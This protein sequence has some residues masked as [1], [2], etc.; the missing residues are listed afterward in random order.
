[1]QIFILLDPSREEIAEIAD[2]L[3]KVLRIKINPQLIIL[4][5]SDNSKL[6]VA[7]AKHFNLSELKN[8]CQDLDI[9]YDNLPDTTISGKARELVEHCIRHGSL[10]KLINTLKELRPHVNWQS[11]H[12]KV[13]IGDSS[14]SSNTSNVHATIRFFSE[15]TQEP[16]LLAQ[17]QVLSTDKQNVFDFDLQS[18]IEG[19][20]FI[21]KL[22]EVAEAQLPANPAEVASEVRDVLTGSL[23]AKLLTTLHLEPNQHANEVLSHAKRGY[24]PTIDDYIEL[25]RSPDYQGYQRSEV[26]ASIRGQRVFEPAIVEVAQSYQSK[27]DDKDENHSKLALVNIVP[28]F[29]DRPQLKLEF[30]VMKYFDFEGPRRAIWRENRPTQF[31]YN[32][33]LNKEI[34]DEIPTPLTCVH[35][36]L[37]TKNMKYLIFGIRRCSVDFWSNRLSVGF[38]EQMEPKDLDDNVFDTVARGIKEEMG[39]SSL[40]ENSTL[41]SIGLEASFFTCS[42]IMFTVLDYEPKEI[43][44]SMSYGPI[45]QEWQPLF[46]PNDV[47]HLLKLLKQSTITLTELKVEHYYDFS[48]PSTFEWHGTSRYRLFTY[49]MRTVGIKKLAKRIGIA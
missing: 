36:I 29:T 39:I 37:A 31:A 21:N 48:L 43:H 15:R 13:Y 19:T 9:I 11:I 5:S 30:E 26:I 49:L 27:R 40:H 23:I 25:A 12:R 41:M 46:I 2:L 45:D 38:E 22:A 4:D 14:A 33:Y 28:S 42:C 18:D 20:E 1:M 16:T 32:H 24:A 35:T 8:L 3:E 6:R 47:N 44:D 17:I 34:P 10:N 7:I